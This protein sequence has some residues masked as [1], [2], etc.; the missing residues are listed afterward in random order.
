MQ[1]QPPPPEQFGDEKLVGRWGIKE[2]KLEGR[3]QGNHIYIRDS[4]RKRGTEKN[5]GGVH[6]EIFRPPGGYIVHTY[7]FY[8]PC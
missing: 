8:V 1:P 3:V 7:L 6:R 5:R 2:N 4:Y